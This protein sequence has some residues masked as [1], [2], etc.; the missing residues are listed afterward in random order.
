MQHKINPSI[1]HLA[2]PIGSLSHYG[3]NPRKHDLNA[4]ADSLSVNGQYRPIV[5]WR[6]DEPEKH[7]RVLAGNGTLK[8]ARDR[9]AWTHI[10]ATWVE[11]TDQ[12]AA[13]IVAADNRISDLAGYDDNL[14]AQV[15]QEA[16][17]EGTGYTQDDLDQMLESLQPEQV[18]VPEVEFSEYVGEHHNY[19]VLTFD[20]D[21]DW[22]A[23]VETFGI[24]TVKAWDARPGYER[25]GLG[26][27][28]DGVAVVRRL[29]GGA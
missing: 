15:L 17:V 20:N 21:I 5:V 22:Q 19:V 14:L 26:R 28:I 16:G 8:A 11:A 3:K 7:G 25:K 12:Q 10:A 2:E 4:I 29:N 1:A 23:A 6:N 13:K 24:R 27:V 18:V 9:L